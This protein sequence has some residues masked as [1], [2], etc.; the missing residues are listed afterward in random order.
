[1]RG[2]LALEDLNIF[3][4]GDAA[5]E[6]LRAHVGVLSESIELLLDLVSQLS[7]VAQ[8]EGGVWLRVLVHLLKDR[9]HEH[10]SLSHTRDGLANNI[11]SHNGLGDALL[12]DFRGVLKTAINDGSVQLVLEQEV[13]EAS[14]VDTGVGGDSI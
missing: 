11:S 2:S 1:M 7:G 5:E 13:F 3:L 4:H 12:L 6:D 9:N 8:D 10:G 14:T